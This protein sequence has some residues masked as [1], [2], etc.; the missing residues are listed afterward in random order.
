MP[1]LR[2]PVGGSLVEGR[3]A[4]DIAEAEYTALRNFYQRAGRLVRR[5]GIRRLST[6]GA[7]T[8]DLHGVGLSAAGLILVGS[9][10]KISRFNVGAGTF[11]DYT[12]NTSGLG[13]AAVPWRFLVYKGITYAMRDGS[14]SLIRIDT[15]GASFDDAGQAQPPTAAVLTDDAG[16]G[17]LAAGVYEGVYTFY[18]SVTGN[19]SLPSA[20]AQ[21]TLAANNHRIDWSSVDAVPAS[22][23][24]AD[25]RRLYRSVLG[26][27]GRYYYV[28]TI[29]D[30]TTTTFADESVLPG[31]MG[32]PARFNDV[33]PSGLQYGCIWRERLFATDGTDVFFSELGLV[34]EFASDA[35]IS[36]APDDL[37]DVTG[38]AAFGERLL[39]GKT[40]G[41][42]YLIGSGPDTFEVRVLSDKHASFGAHSMV[43][44]GS[45]VFWFGGNDFYATDGTVVRNIGDP[46]IRNIISRI[47]VGRYANVYAAVDETRGW[48]MASV[49][50]SDLLSGASNQLVLVYNY[51]ENVWTVFDAPSTHG[52]TALETQY[53]GITSAKGGSSL[54]AAAQYTLSVGIDNHIYMYNDESTPHTT[55]R[56]PSF[57]VPIVAF[58]QTKQLFDPAGMIGVRRVFLLM[59]DLSGQVGDFDLYNDGAASSSKSRTSLSLNIGRR[60][61]A[62]GL[63]TMRKLGSTVAFRFTYADLTAAVVEGLGVEYEVS[64]RIAGRVR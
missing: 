1:L 29:A 5:G 46:N 26:Q 64:R 9:L 11:T 12:D 33:P 50:Q 20:S 56:G 22:N 14:T 23:P 24:W 62:Y 57:E 32:A 54:T 44:A 7:H 16:G 30:R 13:S 36:V 31:A 8:E 2:I 21:V 48:Y 63:S 15:V 39:I 42:Y 3:P 17:T 43:T 49:S 35:V 40:T 10:T 27:T 51:R 52:I 55:D 58:F 18:D 60:W 4:T 47:P 45:Q 59:N 41:I 61:K 6:G 19:E 38:M 53:Q 37:G 28:G 34:E 25:Q